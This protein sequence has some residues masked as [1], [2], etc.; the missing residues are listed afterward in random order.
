[1][2]AVFLKRYKGMILASILF[3][4]LGCG[5]TLSFIRI[6]CAS[7][8]SNAS[9]RKSKENFD[10]NLDKIEYAVLIISNPLNEAKRDAIRATWANFIDN[11]FIENEGLDT[12]RMKKIQAEH[13]RSNDL[14]LLNNF[15]DSYKNLAKKLI[16]SLEWMSNNLKDLKYVIKCDDDSFVRVDLIVRDLEAFAPEMSGP[17]ISQYVTYKKSLPTY[18]GLYWGYFDGRAKVFLNGK[19][20]EKE[21][22]LCDTYLPYAL[23]GGYVISRSIVDYIAKNSQF[24]SHYNSEDVSMGVWTAA[25]DGINRVHDTR[26]DTEW[27]SRG[28]D[29]NMLVRHKQTPMD[30]FQMYKTL[31]HS[32]GTKLCKTESALRKSYHYNWNALPSICCK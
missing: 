28:C 16:H 25:L 3:F 11:I 29:S 18:K 1:M 4:Y 26:F 9:T 20:Q 2:F 5:I 7:P 13:T 21:W 6:E 14:L 27:K 30:M 17:T 31:I 15:E 22:F 24:L 32:Q 8:T 10:N 19:W 12:E 23:G